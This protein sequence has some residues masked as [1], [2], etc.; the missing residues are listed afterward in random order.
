[1]I[2][3]AIA[4]NW[5]LEALLLALSGI[6]ICWFAPLFL[7]ITR[8]ARVYPPLLVGVVLWLM[9]WAMMR[10]ARFLAE[11]QI[12]S[13]IYELSVAGVV[14]LTSLLGIRFYVY[15]TLPLRDW[16]C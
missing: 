15:R 14:V 3:R 8:S 4:R 10:L 13:P 11:R 7:A 12:A 5:Q 6:E 9:V 2:G 16:S 1:M